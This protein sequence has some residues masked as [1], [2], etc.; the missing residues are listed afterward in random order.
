MKTIIYYSI[1]TFPKFS[2]ISSI[3][4]PI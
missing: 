4:F 2:W 3:K 1:Q